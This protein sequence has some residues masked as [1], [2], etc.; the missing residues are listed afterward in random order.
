MIQVRTPNGVGRHLTVTPVEVNGTP[1]VRLTVA[2]TPDA[3]PAVELNLK[4]TEVRT[5]AAALLT[6]LRLDWLIDEL[7][8]TE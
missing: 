6:S 7:E 1:Y 3:A 4:P 5:L 2:T 8:T